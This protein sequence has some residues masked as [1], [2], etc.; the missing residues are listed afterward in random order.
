MSEPLSLCY[1]G[2]KAVFDGLLLSALSA[3]AHTS[4]PLDVHVLTMDLRK[5]KANYLPFSQS[6][7]RILEA[8]LRRKNEQSRVTCYD[9]TEM[10]LRAASRNKNAKNKYTPYAQL[11]LFLSEIEGIPDKVLYLDVDTMCAGDIAPLFDTDIEGYEYAACVDPI[12]KIW[13]DRHYCNAG[14]LLLNCASGTSPCPTS[15]PC[16]SWGSGGCTC[17]ASTTSRAAACARTPS[18]S[19]FARA[20][21]FTLFCPCR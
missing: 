6:Q 13:I 16:T 3:A 20:S 9:L 2:N 12:C 17:P 14:V 5:Q 4:R 21:S 10:Y 18:S 8:A 11:R 15:L 1:A 19:T 7:M